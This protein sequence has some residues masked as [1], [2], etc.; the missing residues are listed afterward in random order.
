[1]CRSIGFPISLEI[2]EPRSHSISHASSPPSFDPVLPGPASLAIAVTIPDQQMK[3]TIERMTQ[4]PHSVSGWI[5]HGIPGGS[6]CAFNTIGRVADSY[7]LQASV[8]ST[9]DTADEDS[10]ELDSRDVC[11]RDGEDKRL[12]SAPARL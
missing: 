10:L 12:V 11:V 4:T 1:M 3:P 9:A 8:R 2:D 6:F 5:S 7:S